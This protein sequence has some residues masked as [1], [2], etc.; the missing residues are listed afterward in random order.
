MLHPPPPLAAAGGSAIHGLGSS[1]EH[2]H[3]GLDLGMMLSADQSLL[4]TGIANRDIAEP[5]AIRHIADLDL[6]VIH[7][8]TPFPSAA[9][10]R[11]AFLS[12]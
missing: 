6:S 8:L 1:V 9:A 5:C 12:C 2:L 10:P 11:D 7:T 3:I 4:P